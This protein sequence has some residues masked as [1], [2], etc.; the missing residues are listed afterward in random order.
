MAR[1]ACVLYLVL[2]G[3][4]AAADLEA[5][6]TA[7]YYRGDTGELAALSAVLDTDPFADQYLSGYLD[8]R[9]GSLLMDSDT[10]EADRVLERG[11]IRLER[12]VERE[13]EYAEAWAVLAAT[14]G[15]RIGVQ[16][17]KRAMRMGPASGK[18][19]SRALKLDPGNPRIQ[20]IAG[21]GKLSTPALFGGGYRKAIRHLDA[22]VEAWRMHGA[23]ALSW[24][25]PDIHVW[26]GIA[27]AHKG[28]KDVAAIEYRAAL[29]IAPDYEWAR[30]VL[31]S[32]SN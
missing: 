26:R 14:L 18:A 8:W 32:L 11:Q 9:L 6:I 13:P 28:K 22:A 2:A 31:S 21:I 27:F 3:G 1:I 20:L 10:A 30:A 4:A 12:L 24:G 19:S 23:G 16:P 17:G 7:A 15:V 5:Q 25:L 29:D